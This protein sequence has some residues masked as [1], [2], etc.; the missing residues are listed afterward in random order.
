MQYSKS[1]VQKVLDDLKQLLP[2]GTTVYTRLNHVSRSGMQRSIT[3][4]VLVDNEPHYLAWSVCVLFGQDLDRYDGVKM[5]GCGM[6]MGFELVYQL[7]YKL[8]PDGFG[9]KSGKGFRASTRE[10]LERYKMSSEYL[11]NP[12][13]AEK[14]DTFCGRNGDTSGWD[15]DGGYALKQRWI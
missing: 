9:V 12:R 13:G 3:P 1:E 7:G 6:D 10:E 11:G 15:S 4:L 2:P 5:N 14:P 8:Y